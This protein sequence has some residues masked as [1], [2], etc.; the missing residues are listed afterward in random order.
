M[1]S[2]NGVSGQKLYIAQFLIEIHIDV[3][4][5]AETRL[6]S[7]Y[8]FQLLKNYNYSIS[9]A[10]VYCLPRFTKTTRGAQRKATL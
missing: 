8:N 7:K 10:A 3:M 5:L 9:I 1:C 4:L 6:T 2:A